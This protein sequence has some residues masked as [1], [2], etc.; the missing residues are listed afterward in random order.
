MVELRIEDPLDGD[1]ID[2]LLIRPEYRTVHDVLRRIDQ[3][4]YIM[5]PD[6]QRSIVWDGRKQSALIESVIM[7]IP[8][9]VFYV[10]QRRDGRM[11]V[12]D[13]LQRLHTFNEFV[14]GDLKLELG[15]ESQ[16]SGKKFDDLPRVLKNR[17]EDCNLIFYIIDPRVSERSRLQIFGRVNNGAPLTRPQMRNAL[18]NGAGTKFLRDGAATDSFKKVT[19]G[20]LSTTEEV[21]SMNDREYINRFCAFHLL[22]VGAYR[23]N[24]DEFLRDSIIH[25]NNM[26]EECLGTLKDDLQR[27]LDNNFTAFGRNAFREPRTA[28]SYGPIRPALWDV[29]T[30][31]L[32]MRKSELVKSRSGE[33]RTEFYRLTGAVAGA[34]NPLEWERS[35]RFM[36]NITNRV[37]PDTLA[38]VRYRFQETREMFRRVFGD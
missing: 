26:D 5:N 4:E 11:V 36:R 10:A 31:G 34:V 23:G 18:Y 2:G 35:D 16:L 6:F 22:G 29:M 7:R 13:G 14:G 38:N 28:Q 24:M 32:A 3:K 12:V 8:L 9:P 15:Q 17:I 37:A 27:G 33:L 25:M 1:P 30:T 19:D 20:K 21:N